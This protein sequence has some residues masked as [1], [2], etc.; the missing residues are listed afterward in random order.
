M[1]FK[2]ESKV[3][4]KCNRGEIFR[5]KIYLPITLLFYTQYHFK[6]SHLLSGGFKSVFI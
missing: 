3:N 6:T 2:Q 5:L 1:M 4:K